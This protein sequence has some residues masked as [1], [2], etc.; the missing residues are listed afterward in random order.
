MT[1]TYIA[2][3]DIKTQWNIHAKLI[4][5]EGDS[6]WCASAV[7]HLWKQIMNICCFRVKLVETILSR[8]LLEVLEFWRLRLR[9]SMMTSSIFRTKNWQFLDQVTDH[10]YWGT[11]Q[12][13]IIETHSFKMTGK[14]F[15]CRFRFLV[16]FKQSSSC[17]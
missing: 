7:S 5:C 13:L 12:Q 1:E 17:K 16:Q 11:P 4:F 15:T 3:N 9:W 6:L 8:Q 2:T 14:N 10:Y